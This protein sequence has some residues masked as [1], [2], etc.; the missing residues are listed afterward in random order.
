MPPR[1]GVWI[2]GRLLPEA[3]RDALLGDL[4]EEHALLAQTKSPADAT[5]WYWSQVSR[6]VAALAWAAAR[7]GLWLATLGAGV[8][9]YGVVKICESTAAMALGNVFVQQP[10][11]RAMSAFVVGVS[12]MVLGGFVAARLRR[13]AAAAV[14]LISAVMVLQWIAGEG[15]GVALPFQLYFLVACPAAAIAGGALVRKHS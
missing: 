7:R 14:A 6:S 13:G 1:P 4:M 5:R 15:R 12:G 2:L 8:V 11:L 9:G 3:N 10:V